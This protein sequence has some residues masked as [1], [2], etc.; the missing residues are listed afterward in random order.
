VLGRIAILLLIVAAALGAS[1]PGW[2]T[3]TAVATATVRLTAKVTCEDRARTPRPKAALFGVDEDEDEDDPLGAEG[4]RLLASGGK[5]APHPTSI[6]RRTAF[7]G[8]PAGSSLRALLSSHPVR[9]PPV[10]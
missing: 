2:A 1:L 10:A 7:G 3:R 6:V 9:G 5:P 4:E 8:V